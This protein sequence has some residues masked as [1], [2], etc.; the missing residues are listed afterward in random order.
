MR[1][2]LIITKFDANWR[3]CVW[4]A[5]RKRREFTR[6]D[7][8]AC[9]AATPR[10]ITDYLTGLARAGYIEPR[11]D[12]GFALVKD[13]GVEAPMVRW[14]G[15]TVDEHR[16][17]EQLWRTAKILGEFTVAELIVHASTDELRVR[18]SFAKHYARA[19]LHGGYIVPVIRGTASSTT[20]FRLLSSRYTGPKPP[21]IQYLM[22]V[23]D[24]NT[25]KVVWQAGEEGVS[26]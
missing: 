10:A 22:Q 20:R 6:A 11:G 13:V 12:D 19:L 25:G 1:G 26:V 15:R 2:P 17:R 16:M 3:D 4:K 9:K 5:I 8:E 23:F 7:L 14:N 24:A 21:V 18:A